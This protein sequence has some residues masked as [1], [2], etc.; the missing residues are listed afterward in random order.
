MT[1]R[2]PHGHSSCLSPLSSSWP[3]G[4]RFVSILLLPTHPSWTAIPHRLYHPFPPTLPTPHSR[5]SPSAA[6]PPPPLPSPHHGQPSASYSIPASRISG[7][8]C[9]MP[10]I[11]DTLTLHKCSSQ[12]VLRST[13]GP[14]YDPPGPPRTQQLPVSPLFALLCPSMPPVYT[15][16]ISVCL[17]PTVPHPVP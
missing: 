14:G 6:L 2:A 17:T 3:T 11:M 15:G 4:S 8:L 12:M 13:R 5:S 9:T 10:A 7:L 16:S 1:H